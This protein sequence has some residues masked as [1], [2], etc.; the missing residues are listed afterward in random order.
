MN[1]TPVTTRTVP[2]FGL[3]FLSLAAIP[4]LHAADADLAIQPSNPV[5]SLVSVP[6]QSNLD[7]ATG[8][9]G[10]TKWTTNF[11]PV[12]PFGLNEDWNLISRTILPVIDQQGIA[13]GGTADAFGLGD[14]TRSFFFSPRNPDPFVWDFTFLFPKS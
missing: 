11:Q 8:S 12:I 7:F 2:P 9:G 6:V 4:S 14:I 5:A 13:F 3:A 10:G 1:S